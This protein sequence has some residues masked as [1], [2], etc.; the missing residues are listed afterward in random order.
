ML[1]PVGEQLTRLFADVPN[2]FPHAVIDEL[3]IM[4][5]HVHCIIVIDYTLP[6]VQPGTGIQ[7]QGVEQ[8]LPQVNQFGKPVAGSI[9][10]IIG[11]VK[12]VL[13]KWCN[14]NGHA[15][16]NWQSRFYDHVIRDAKSHE[17]IRHYIQ[18]NPSCWGNDELFTKPPP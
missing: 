15:Y 14:K 8:Y 3:V 16:F 4:P 2:H 6:G 18:N 10:V 9:S 1:S 13:K 5:N 7:K 17:A 12:T 11:Q